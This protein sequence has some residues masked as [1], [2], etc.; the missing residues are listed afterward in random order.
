MPALSHLHQLAGGLTFSH[1]ALIFIAASAA[2][3]II[4]YTRML[5]LRRKMPPGPFPLP[6]IGNTHLLP[7]RKPWIYFET[8]S[9]QYNSGIITFW[10]GRNP[11]VW[12]NDSKS[13]SDLLDK[14]AATFS[15]RPRM[16]VFGEL[17]F[18]Q[19]SLVTMKYGERF[20]VHRKLTHMGIGLQQV[21]NYQK[22]QSD[23]N[24]VVLRNLLTD[25]ENYVA[26]FERYA[27]SV[28]SIIGFGRRISQITD[29]IITEVIFLM[30]RAAER[31]VPGK[32]FPML[33]ETFP[34]LAKFPN[35][36]A[37]WKKGLG[38]PRAKNF[39]Y[40]LAE[41]AANT[42]GGDN[43]S[44]K[45]F[46]QAPKYNLSDMELST[47]AGSLFGAGSDTS[48][49]TLITF[50]LA[51]CAFPES[52]PKAWEELD[53]VVG[54]HR[55]PGFED[56]K[57]LVYVKALVKEVLRWRSVA[58]LGGQPHAP[59]RDE[60]YQDW[61]IPKDTWVQGNVWA[62]HRNEKDFPD[63]DR[64]NPE[65]YLESNPDHRPFPN[66]RGYMTFGWG[67]RVCAGQALAEQ[68][69]FIS[70]ARLLWAFN[71]QKAVDEAGNDIPVDI[72]DYTDGL[73]IRPNLFKC[74]ITPRN[75]EIRKTIEREGKQATEDLSVYNGETKFRISTYSAKG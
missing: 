17:A 47:L 32:T 24:K 50:V 9:K 23:E 8:L 75:E 74:R 1:V 22:L 34:W 44:K 63:P 60:I 52:L 41:E 45:L 11:T 54:P 33:M 5:L 39:F 10:I 56:E 46:E 12:L 58:I 20:R 3:L 37:P 72:F 53:R 6:I 51:C 2:L 28:V 4:D 35:R 26:H 13:A 43:Y 16:I 49:S 55:S 69:T 59:I 25:S 62:I 15:S 71:I 38:T 36:I 27:A 66:E 29:P 31:N 57:D 7:D 30:Q 70:V 19:T 21:R 67:R 40:A 68:G 73:N 64:F 18:D 61:L 14:R 48:S 65:R 42:E